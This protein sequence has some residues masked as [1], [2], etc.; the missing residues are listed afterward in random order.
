[1]SSEGSGKINLG[2][3]NVKAIFESAK[4]YFEFE[5]YPLHHEQLSRLADVERT[6]LVR[7]QR[8]HAGADARIQFERVASSQMLRFDHANVPQQTLALR[9]FCVPER[10]RQVFPGQYVARPIK[11]QQPRQPVQ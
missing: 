1:M 9:L 7:R 8:L 11:Q 5:V 4:Y 2:T 3:R 6:F 10:V